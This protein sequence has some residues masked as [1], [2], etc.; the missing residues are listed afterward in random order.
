MKMSV[1][2]PPLGPENL[3]KGLYALILTAVC[4]HHTSICGNL[5]SDMFNRLSV[6]LEL[7]QQIHSSRQVNSINV[8]HGERLMI[9]MANLEKFLSR[10]GL[11]L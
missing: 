7:T 1:L 10:C 5:V 3:P 4:W 2:C 9:F 8:P 6:R 11:M